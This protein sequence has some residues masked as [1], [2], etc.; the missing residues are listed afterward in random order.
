MGSTIREFFDGAGTSSHHKLRTNLETTFFPQS[1]VQCSPRVPVHP[2]SVKYSTNFRSSSERS[3]PVISGTKRYVTSIPVVPQR[4]VYYNIFG[5]VKYRSNGVA[6]QIPA[7]INVHLY[8][9][10]ECYML[11]HE[12]KTLPSAQMR[13]NRREGLCSNCSSSFPHSSGYSITCTSA[14]KLKRYSEFHGGN[15]HRIGVG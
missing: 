4:A 10:H 9:F 3:I 1:S 5:E 7:I 15:T 14:N 6:K 13:L 8:K 2:L 11:R 12:G